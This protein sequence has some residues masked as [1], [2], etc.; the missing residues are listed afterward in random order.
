MKKIFKI[1]SFL[2]LLSF[3]VFIISC[4]KNDS[5]PQNI[6]QVVPNS[7]LRLKNVTFENGMLKF[8]TKADFDSA[9]ALISRNMTLDPKWI[10]LQFSGFES[11]HLEFLNLV[12]S[13]FA[14]VIKNDRVG[15]QYKNLAQ[16]IQVEGQNT[17][18]ETITTL[19]I[20]LVANKNGFLSISKMVY[21][22]TS[23]GVVSINKE[24]YLANLNSDFEILKSDKIVYNKFSDNKPIFRTCYPDNSTVLL[25]HGSNYRSAG[26]V[27]HREYLMNDPNIGDFF[28]YYLDI[29]LEFEGKNSSGYWHSDWTHY[30]QANGQAHFTYNID[31][32][33][34]RTPVNV[35]VPLNTSL[36]QKNNYN[37]WQVT[38]C[39]TSVG[40]Y[41]GPE[42]GDF[43]L[44]DWNFTFYYQYGN[45]GTPPSGNITYSN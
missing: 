18:F 7:D 4:N 28:E 44:T 13:K 17:I 36:G 22:F 25:T 38:S 8:K 16:I 27:W 23:N 33:F 43:C 41:N 32:P 19:P 14:N 20:S 24:F 3:I 12:E 5:E 9:L 37:F 30:M 42:S 39:Y 2:F 10:N 29:W 21:K 45:S 26:Y 31:G 35:T 11:H 34:G 1:S 40:P 6:S 15:E